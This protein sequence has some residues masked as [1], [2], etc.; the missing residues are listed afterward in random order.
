MNARNGQRGPSRRVR[1]AA[2][3]DPAG[4]A[5][6]WSWLN[7]AVVEDVPPEPLDAD[8][9]RHLGTVLLLVLTENV[10]HQ[11]GLEPDQARGAALG[12]IAAK[13]QEAK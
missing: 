8:M 4:E 9:A 7:R 12:W 2:E 13:A 1:A 11:L 6:I 10:R 3:H 5:A